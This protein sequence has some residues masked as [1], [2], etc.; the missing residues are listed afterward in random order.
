[1]KTGLHEELSNKTIQKIIV[2]VKCKQNINGKKDKIV[3]KYTEH[4]KNLQPVDHTNTNKIVTSSAPSQ[5][6][7]KANPIQGMP[8]G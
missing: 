3:I 8:K 5:S 6:T 1:M 2:I 4:H 7:V